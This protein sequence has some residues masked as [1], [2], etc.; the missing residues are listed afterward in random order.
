MF[1]INVFQL[2]NISFTVDFV[3]WLQS[4]SLEYT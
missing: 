3:I 1:T 4:A 2:I